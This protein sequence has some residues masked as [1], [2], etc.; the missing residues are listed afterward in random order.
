MR[1]AL[2]KPDQRAVVLGETGRGDK[3]LDRYSSKVGRDLAANYQR[4]GTLAFP[5]AHGSLVSRV[6][7]TA[8]LSCTASVSWVLAVLAELCEYRRCIT[9]GQGRRFFK[10]SL[11]AGEAVAV[12]FR[13]Q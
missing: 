3:S 5:V 11:T 12:P 8:D 6:F 13:G 2:A 9:S 4:V 10:S 7:A 1:Y